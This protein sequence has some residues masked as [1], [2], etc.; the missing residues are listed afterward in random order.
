MRIVLPT[1][2]RNKVTLNNME[3][4]SWYDIYENK[5]AIDRVQYL[6]DGK[7]KEVQEDIWNRYNQDD[8]I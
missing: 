2:N 4:N 7:Q 1:A 5:N 8:M 6:K 3:M